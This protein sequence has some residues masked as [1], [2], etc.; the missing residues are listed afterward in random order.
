VRLGAPV[1]LVA[2]LLPALALAA[3]LW[4]ERRPSR[5]AIAYPNLSVLAGVARRGHAWRR[6]VTAALLA[7]A[8]ALLCVAVARPHMSLTVPSER[9]TVVLALDLSGSMGAED[10]EPN[11]LDAAKTAIRA[12][13]DRLPGQLSVGLV[14]FSSEPYVAVPPTRDRD[15]V[16][17]GLEMALPQFGTA[18]GDSVARSAELARETLDA[19]ADD[20]EGVAG[21]GAAAQEP[22]AATGADAAV[23]PLGAVVF[24]SDGFQTRG[25]LT[26]EE[27][28]QRAK[29]AGIPVHTIALG[30]DGG[31]IEVERYGERRT[32]PVPPDRP[33][34]AAI[35]RTTGGEAFDVRDAE[36]LS[37]VYERLGSAVG[38]V[39]EEREV[40]AAFVAAGAAALSV[41]GLL[42]GLWAPRL[43]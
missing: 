33:T 25:L 38:R 4:I 3:Y 42:A 13:L 37:Q 1:F 27:G 24:L 22:P 8:L 36:R 10:V 12:F 26:P 18:I 23:E 32:I 17:A 40:T 14:L 30:T 2:L 31:V 39:E 15:A 5:Y 21:E 16:R 6:H 28:A 34:L 29:E 9:A 35:A 7:G 19:T 20:E 41:A 43:P 11:R